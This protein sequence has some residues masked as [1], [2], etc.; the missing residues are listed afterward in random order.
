V[1]LAFFAAAPPAVEF[2][3]PMTAVLSENFA[4]MGGGRD[5]S[6]EQNARKKMTA[7]EWGK[8]LHLWCHFYLAPGNRWSILA[9]H[10]EGEVA[11]WIWSSTCQPHARCSLHYAW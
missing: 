1:V 3:L 10:C 8:Q 2:L 11:G 4:G 5:A 6:Q 7:T 9:A